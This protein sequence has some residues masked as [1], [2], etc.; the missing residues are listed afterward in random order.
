MFCFKNVFSKPILKVD[1]IREIGFP[2]SANIQNAAVGLKKGPRLHLDSFWKPVCSVK[3]AL[4]GLG[5][6]C[7]YNRFQ[8]PICI[9]MS[10]LLRA[11]GEE[12]REKVWDIYA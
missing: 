4:S 9:C 7:F 8:S 12:E 6:H 10:S 1:Q 3:R 11:K 5:V 2:F